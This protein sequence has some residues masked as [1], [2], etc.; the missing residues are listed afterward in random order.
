MTGGEF[1]AAIEKARVEGTDVELPGWLG[2][3]DGSACA[4][5]PDYDETEFEGVWPRIGKDGC[6]AHDF[7]KA[8]CRAMEP[9]TGDRAMALADLVKLNLTMDDQTRAFIAD[10]WGGEVDVRGMGTGL[11]N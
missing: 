5:I 3:L 11:L 2:F 10:G 4:P 9:D 1:E 8:L 6:M 7:Q